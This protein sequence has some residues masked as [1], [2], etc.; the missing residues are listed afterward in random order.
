[1]EDREK[2]NLKN[3]DVNGTFFN[4]FKTNIKYI[5]I[6][7]A[8]VSILTFL[9][10]WIS[11]PIIKWEFVKDE[12]EALIKLNEALKDLTKLR[13][14]SGICI[15]RLEEQLKKRSKELEELKTNREALLK[16]IDELKVQNDKNIEL[17]MQLNNIKIAN[18]KQI[19]QLEK[20]IKSNKEELASLQKYKLEAEKT[21]I[22]LEN[23]VKG[24]YPPSE[25]DK[26]TKIFS[27]I[28]ESKS[29]PDVKEMIKKNNYYD[30]EWNKKGE[31]A[32]NEFVLKTRNGKKIV[33]DRVRGLVWQ[34]SGSPSKL[35]YPNAILYIEI[36][37]YN[38]YAGYNDWRLPNLEEAMSLMENSKINNS[39][40]DP[41]FD[42]KQTIICTSSFFRGEYQ[43]WVVDFLNGSCHYENYYSKFFV[44]AVRSE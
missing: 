43:P 15:E 11:I 8:F 33:K 22:K 20:N 29:I 32:K 35:N 13:K 34:K 19:K 40:I 5:T 28:T 37:N 27:S 10:T 42:S 7:S 6:I 38:R 44:R 30:F 3:Y 24:K 14:E 18:E 21:I 12:N 31:G 25:E 1:M 17:I 9:I 16:H 26:L 36:L 39:Y 23:Y 41:I 4:W 2:P